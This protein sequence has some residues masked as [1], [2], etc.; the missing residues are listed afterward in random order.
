MH[1]SLIDD[2]TAMKRLGKCVLAMVG[3]TGLLLVAIS[4]AV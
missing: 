1:H 2:S 3:I 4:I